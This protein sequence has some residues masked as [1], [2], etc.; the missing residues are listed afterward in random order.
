M[1]RVTECH[2]PVGLALRFEAW[3]LSPNASTTGYDFDSL[4]FFLFA[5]V[6]SR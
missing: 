1:K 2:Q 4:E 6:N 5:M 3:H